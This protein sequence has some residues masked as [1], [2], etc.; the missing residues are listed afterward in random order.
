MGRDSH[1]LRD[2][3]VSM[4]DTTSVL[5]CNLGVRGEKRRTGQRG[6][7]EVHVHPGFADP[8]AAP[9]NIFPPGQP[10]GGCV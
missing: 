5:R 8:L 4:G 2:E 3:P 9:V 7:G 1:S 10:E 6:S